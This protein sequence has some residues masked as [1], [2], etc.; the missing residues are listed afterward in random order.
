MSQFAAYD[1]VLCYP[2]RSDPLA[3]HDGRVRWASVCGWRVV[4]R[5]L[6][7]APSRAPTR[8]ATVDKRA[9]STASSPP[10]APT[11]RGD[12]RHGQRLGGRDRHAPKAVLLRTL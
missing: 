7:A 10:P 2:D 8:E 9:R 11:T 4:R 1:Y 6:A 12:A 3:D 5:P